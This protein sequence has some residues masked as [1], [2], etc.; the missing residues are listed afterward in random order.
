MTEEIQTSEQNLQQVAEAPTQRLTAEDA[1]S[2]EAESKQAW[3]GVMEGI[4]ESGSNQGDYFIDINPKNTTEPG[5]RRSIILKTPVPVS[6]A[7]ESPRYVVITRDGAFSAGYENNDEFIKRMQ[8]IKDNK[9][10][11]GYDPTAPDKPKIFTGG[12]GS[13]ERMMDFQ[14]VP[15]SS[16][17]TVG[18]AI[19]QSILHTEAPHRAKV[20]A[21]KTNTNMAN[22][23]G[24]FVKGL[25]AR[26]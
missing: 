11:G 22:T 2:A 13:H 14:L 18:K 21:A 16:A 15:L 7:E 23:V 6:E 9:N 12:Y 20:E 3:G 19:N 24:S 17:D 25:P 5:N 1:Q 8:E 26:A 4:V 10:E